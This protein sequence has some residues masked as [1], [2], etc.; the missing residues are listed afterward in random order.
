MSKVQI[1]RSVTKADADAMQRA[2]DALASGRRVEALGGGRYRVESQSAPGTWHSVQ[3][4]NVP[5][6]VASCDCT[7]AQKGG[8]GRCWHTAEVLALEVRRLARV[9]VPAPSRAG[10]RLTDAECASR[11]RALGGYR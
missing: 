2:T 10:R 7:H 8:R 3:V 5:E 9:P 4:V 1:T 6:L 11:M